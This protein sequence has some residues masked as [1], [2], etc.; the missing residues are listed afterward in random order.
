MDEDL[1][2]MLGA[3]QKWGRDIE[4]VTTRVA[5]DYAG[6]SGPVETMLPEV[7]HNITS[8][9]NDLLTQGGSARRKKLEDYLLHL[10]TWY[11]A[12]LGGY[13]KALER[14]CGEFLERLSPKAIMAKKPSNKVFKALGMDELFYWKVFEE[15]MRNINVPTVMEEFEEHA[16]QAAMEIA[17]RDRKAPLGK[18]SESAQF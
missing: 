16:A 2:F 1:L 6:V 11:V 5:Q 15:T 9:V 3:I 17:N 12:C 7:E 4:R 8:L 13:R 10:R 14:W 18:S